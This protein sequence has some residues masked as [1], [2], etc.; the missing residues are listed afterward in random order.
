[1]RWF[2]LAAFF[3]ASCLGARG[4][5]DDRAQFQQWIAAAP[6]RAEAFA[7]FELQLRD[8]GVDT[9]VP[10]HQ[11]WM[12][13][14]LRP[15]CAGE[16]FWAPPKQEWARIIPALRF[17]RDHLKPALGEVRVVSGYRSESFNACVRGAPQ[18]A[19]RH[20]Q[21]LD[22]VPLNDE[23][24]REALID[25]LCPI[26]ASAGARADIGLGIYSG[27]RFHIDARGFRGWGADF[28]RA[29]FPCDQRETA[30]VP[31]H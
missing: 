23:L 7:A 2:V 18:S 8:A 26:H 1:M 11:L 9:V 5:V 16:A 6:E 21:A 27:V 12:V 13:D 17:I 15:E 4:P 28:R 24:T 3:L 19:H 20:Y 22:L 14:R 30:E 10:P 25:L 31:A 29:T